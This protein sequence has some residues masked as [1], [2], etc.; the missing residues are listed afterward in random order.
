[1]SRHLVACVLADRAALALANAKLYA[2]SQRLSKAKSEILAVTSHELRTP[3]NAIIGYA[4]LLE[5]GITG[6]VT[7]AQ[8]AQLR[9]IGSAAKHL[10]S[11]INEI[12]TL[13]SIEAGKQQLDL[14][15]IDLVSTLREV[16]DMAESSAAA[17]GL[18]LETRLP[19]GAV[20]IT[21]D[22]T[23]LRQVVLNLLSNSVKFTAEGSVTLAVDWSEAEVAV[24]VADT[25]IGIAPE[26]LDLVFEPF[27]QEDHRNVG[28]A[29]GTGL[30]L[31]VSREL[32]RLMGGDLTATS[33]RGVGTVFQ[34]RLPR[35]PEPAPAGS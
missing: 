10:L 5:D 24:S 21:T 14:E 17:K 12:L 13:A 6:P 29:S 34:L 20:M 7:E 3:L 4:S 27:F 23:K 32:A 30:G 15:E 19:A 26:H 11:L 25:G 22:A 2:E 18:R 16:A 33:T 8:A 31:A 9:R 35:Q 28:Q 1:M